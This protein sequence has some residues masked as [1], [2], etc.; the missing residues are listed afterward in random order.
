MVTT[1]L[2]AYFGSDESASLNFR[3]S[4]RPLSVTTPTFAPAAFQPRPR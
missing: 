1:P 3:T 2:A 4:S